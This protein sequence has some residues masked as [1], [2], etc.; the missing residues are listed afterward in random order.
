MVYNALLASEV[1]P[2]LLG[3]WKACEYALT[4]PRFHLGDLLRHQLLRSDL[5]VQVQG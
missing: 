1:D 2:I 5:L 3:L 4:H